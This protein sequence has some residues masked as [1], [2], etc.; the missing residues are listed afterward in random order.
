MAEEYS[1]A[2]IAELTARVVDNLARWRFLPSAAVTLLNV[3]ENATFALGDPTGRELV[4]RVH[5]IGYS[6]A[7]E[8]RSELAWMNALRR[9]GVIETAAAV[10]GADGQYVQVL[11]SSTGGTKR[12]AV[13]F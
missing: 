8:I 10:A 9:D 2:V 11:A 13:A 5:R 12:F 4:L 3:S 7:E 1:P 6:S